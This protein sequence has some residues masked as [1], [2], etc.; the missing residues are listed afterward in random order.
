MEFRS[1]EVWVDAVLAGRISETDSGYRFNY[2]AAY[3][4]RP[5]ALPVSLGLPLQSGP[6]TSQILFPFFDGL[7]PEG[8]LLAVAEKTWKLDSRDRMGLLLACCR[9]CIGNV[10]VISGDA[11]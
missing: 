7:I 5:E 1:G 6:Y 11:A 8:W 10:S 4:A 2:E 3:L 9:E